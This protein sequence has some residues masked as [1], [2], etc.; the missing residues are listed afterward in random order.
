MKSN[1]FFFSFL[2]LFGKL[3]SQSVNVFDHISSGKADLI[4]KSLHSNDY[5]DSTLFLWSNNDYDKSTYYVIKAIKE[6]NAEKTTKYIKMAIICVKDTLKRNKFD[7]PKEVWDSLFSKYPLGYQQYLNVVISEL[8]YTAPYQ[9]QYL[10]IDNDALLRNMGNK[11]FL[12]FSYLNR[13]SLN[14]EVLDNSIQALSIID[15]AIYIWIDLGDEMQLANNYKYKGLILSSLGQI[16]SSMKYINTAINLYSKL[17]FDAGIYSCILDKVDAFSQNSV[18]DSILSNYSLTSGFYAKNDIFRFFI[19][20][21]NLLKG[22]NC[23]TFEDLQPYIEMNNSLY[24]DPNILD[25]NRLAYLKVLIKIFEHNSIDNIPLNYKYD[26][27]YYKMK[28]LDYD[29]ILFE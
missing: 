2:L 19:L 26:K 15:S 3:Y 14:Y 11:P 23:F 10:L 5:L 17:S 29:Q 16:D 1:I 7:L 13:A 9:C 24:D 25:I 27:L 18:C 6:D 8:F 21:I 12:A 4:C 22:Y 20:N 28:R